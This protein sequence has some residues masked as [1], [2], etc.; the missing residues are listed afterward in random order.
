M[1]NRVNIGRFLTSTTKSSHF[2]RVQLFYSPS[3]TDLPIIIVRCLVNSIRL[4]L[5]FFSSILIINLYFMHFIFW[6]L[7]ELSKCHY[8]VYKKKK[9][10]VIIVA[11]YICFTSVDLG[12]QKGGGNAGAHRE[13]SAPVH[14]VLA[15]SGS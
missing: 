5:Y 12:M 10:N 1:Y 8:S 3:N 2:N 7:F 4:F 14:L 15:L 9:K 6:L 13:R 11:I